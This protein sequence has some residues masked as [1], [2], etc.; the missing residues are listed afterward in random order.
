MKPLHIFRAG[1]HT[2]MRGEALA[3]SEGDLAA[4]AAAYDPALSEAPLVVGH[5]STDAPAYGWVAA[6]RAEG[7]DLVAEPRQ[8]EPQFAELVKDGRFKHRSA[9]FYPPT[10]PRNPKPGVYYLKHVGFLGAAPPAVKGLKPVAFADDDG[11]VTV[12]FAAEAITPW[13][14][15]FLFSDIGTLFRGM[16]DWM[17]AEK[18]VEQADRLLPPGT[19][20]RIAEEA[21]R[22]Q[23]E[24]DAAARGAATEAPPAFSTPPTTEDTVTEKNPTGGEDATAALRRELDA[25]NA[26]LAQFAE[27]AARA[28][29]AEA[30]AFVAGLVREARLPAGLVPRVVAFMETLPAD[31]EVSFSEAGKAVK[32]SPRDAFRDLLRGLPAGIQF[33][34][35]AGGDG[36]A[37]GAVVSFAGHRADPERAELDAKVREHQRKHGGDYLAALRAVGAMG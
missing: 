19:V 22:M 28:R 9:S 20:S 12:Q 8:V 27:D 2:P 32:Q 3:F 25:A 6:L 18:G 7:A 15:S 17:V 26:R 37:D 31:G 13:R 33:G 10:H 36:P 5:P 21:A 29:R 4:M 11:V 30:E 14:L 34:E 23:G 24:A 1:R 35:H 16:R